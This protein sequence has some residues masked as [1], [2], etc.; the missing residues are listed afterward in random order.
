MAQ[1]ILNA[2]LDAGAREALALDVEGT[3]LVRSGQE[4]PSTLC[5]KKRFQSSVLY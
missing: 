2:E 1:C 4:T 5:L 3:D